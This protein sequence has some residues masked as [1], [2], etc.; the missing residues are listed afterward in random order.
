MFLTDDVNTF[1]K[2]AVIRSQHVQR[3]WDLDKKMPQEDVDLLVHAATNCPSKQN[4]R[5]YDL[6]VI[7]D[8]DVIE[9]VYSHT[10]G[11]AITNPETGEDDFTTNSQVLAHTLFVFTDTERSERY[12]QKWKDDDSA[13]DISWN[14]DQDMAIGVAAGY[15]NVIASQLG[16]GT[17][18]CA[19]FVSE[20]VVKELNLNS[21]VILMMGVGIKGT[22]KNRRIHQE[23]GVMMPIHPKEPI[24]VTYI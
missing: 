6:H 8:R 22:D 14:R 1:I 2:K 7:Q 20:K 16:Y 12:L 18:C 21:H 15:I 24:N 10:K 11:I 23:T 4:F 9:R 13:L 19:C 5:F 17:G 3:N